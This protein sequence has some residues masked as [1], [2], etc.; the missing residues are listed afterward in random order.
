MAH[1]RVRPVRVLW[2]SDRACAVRSAMA[3]RANKRSCA[4]RASPAGK[5][6]SVR[7][8]DIH[9]LCHKRGQPLKP[10]YQLLGVLPKR[11]FDKSE[12]FIRQHQKTI[13]IGL[14]DRGSA[15]SIL[16]SAKKVAFRL[17]FMLDCLLNSDPGL[18]GSLN[19]GVGAMP[20]EI[21]KGKSHISCD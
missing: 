10:D 21:I 5:I 11:V 13:R 20:V 16:E 2:S 1:F 17:D 19:V 3:P 9:V 12:W 14:R 7:W 15:W 4:A 8:V 6:T 18:L